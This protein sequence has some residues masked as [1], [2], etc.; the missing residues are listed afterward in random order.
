MNSV[1]PSPRLPRRLN[2]IVVKELRQ[3][4]RSRFVSGVFVL[5]LGVELFAI[6]MLLLTRSAKVDP[7]MYLGRDMFQLLFVL[8]SVA[9]L[10]FI[11]LYA[12]VRLA[13]E[14][15]DDNLDLLFITTIKPGA[16]IRGKLFAAVAIAVLLFA[17]AAPFMSFSYLLRGIDIPSIFV[18]LGFVFVVVVAVTQAALFLACLPASRVFK[19]LLGLAS[20]GGLFAIVITVNAFG[21]DLVRRGVGSRFGTWD[22]WAA[23][24]SVVGGLWL[25]AGLVQ[26]LAVALISPPSA[27]R[28]LPVR[29]YATFGWLVSGIWIFVVARV[30][31]E[32]EIL[33]VWLVGSMLL[34]SAAV[35]TGLSEDTL[36]S[37]RV[38]RAIPRGRLAR[39]MA[40]LFYNGPAGA[41]CWVL[42]LAAATVAATLLGAVWAAHGGVDGDVAEMTTAFSS[43][44]LYNVAYGL[45]AALIYRR[46]FARRFRPLM[47][48]PIAVTLIMVGAL[49]PSLVALLLGDH[50]WRDPVAWYMGNIF[51]VGARKCREMHLVFSGT[52][53]TA[54]LAANGRWLFLQMRD[55]VPPAADAV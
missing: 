22:F 29:A 26:R 35:L 31:R 9:C 46:L 41:L 43:F 34:L 45:T 48:W 15:W 10:A 1:A 27:N 17:A 53:A 49:L 55:F 18:A 5:F 38:R 39:R 19:L 33:L 28:A 23:S 4:V 51:T 7:A 16:I 52:W 36:L 2:P 12:G 47:V 8:L 54:M 42:L 11:P 32:E 3:A 37:A 6:G 14:R 30:E 13:M 21:W 50:S 20:V 24:A 40:F 25:A 44:L